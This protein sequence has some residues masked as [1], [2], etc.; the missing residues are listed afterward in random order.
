MTSSEDLI[1]LLGDNGSIQRVPRTGYDSEAMLQSLIERYPEL[2]AGEQIDPHEPTRWLLVRREAGIP[3]QEDSPDRWAVDHLLLD[4]RG[5]PTFVEV[6][7][8]SDT[9][10]RREVIGQMLDYAANAQLYWPTDRIRALAAET[11]GGVDRL[12][13]RV[14]ELLDAG[15]GETGIESYW[16]AVD[17]NLRTGHVRLL[18][19]ADELPAEVRR[20]IEFLNEQMP[21]VDVLGVELRHYSS[22]DV[23]ALVP[24]VI[25]QTELVRQ[26]KRSSQPTTRTTQDRFL[27]ECPEYSRALFAQILE[28]AKNRSLIVYWGSKGFSIRVPS[29]EGLP[30]SILYGFPTGAL[31]R[32]HPSLEA[33][34]RELAPEDNPV[35]VRGKLLEAA[36]FQ[37]A[38]SYT[39]RLTVLDTNIPEA[40]RAMEVVW[41]L[42][43]HLLASGTNA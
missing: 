21:R 41:E 20:V 3:G 9:R 15:T 2:L 22:A 37:E 10:I 12:D 24:R 30:K 11:H 36:S 34:L 8:Q 43:A 18:F 42:A 35:G 39:L 14:R 31:G 38:G 27:S 40:T 1:F 5:R 28:T 4:Q 23:R 7:R 17:E 16:E 25:G 32:E 33:Y 19:V 26:R 29:A 6:E 13:D